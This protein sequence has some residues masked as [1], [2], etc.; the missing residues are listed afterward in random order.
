MNSQQ[1]KTSNDMCRRY[2]QIC[3]KKTGTI[4]VYVLMNVHTKTLPTSSII[5]IG[6]HCIKEYV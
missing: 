3:Q 2:L 1:L 4:V 5:K 6:K